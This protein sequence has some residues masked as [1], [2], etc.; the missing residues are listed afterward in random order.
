MS[1]ILWMLSV[2]HV[3]YIKVFSC[4][5]ATNEHILHLQFAR[6][7]IYIEIQFKSCTSGRC[8]L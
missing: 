8:E 3:I 2:I 7:L 1:Q 4:L 6:T 5:D